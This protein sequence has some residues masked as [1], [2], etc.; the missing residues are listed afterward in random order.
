LNYVQERLKEMYSGEQQC[1]VTIN[2]YNKLHDT[3]CKYSKY[4][5]HIHITVYIIFIYINIIYTL[6]IL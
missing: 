4:H 2:Y 5:L 6:N 3:F 1:A